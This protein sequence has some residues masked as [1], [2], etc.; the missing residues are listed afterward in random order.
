MIYPN[1]NIFGPYPL[2][3][4]SDASIDCRHLHRGLQ[5]S[6]DSCIK[7]YLVLDSDAI[8]I[9]EASLT[10]CNTC[11]VYATT[12]CVE[13][14]ASQKWGAMTME[15]TGIGVVLRWIAAGEIVVHIHGL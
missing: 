2:A 13:T 10:T 3:G 1:V 14:I 9:T 15:I 7:R 5:L 12:A 4:R 6:Q 11:K 8:S